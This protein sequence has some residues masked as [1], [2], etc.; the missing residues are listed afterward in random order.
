MR[1]PRLRFRH[2]Q[3]KP[4]PEAPLNSQD[5]PTETDTPPP[6]PNRAAS[7]ATQV[8]VF[9]HNLKLLWEN[10]LAKNLPPRSKIREV[11][12]IVT[13]HSMRSADRGAVIVGGSLGLGGLQDGSLDPLDEADQELRRSRRGAGALLSPEDKDP[14]EE[15]P[16]GAEQE[17]AP[18]KG[19]DRTH[20]FNYYAFE[21]RTGAARWRC[22]RR[23][24][25]CSC[26][27]RRNS[28]VKCLFGSPFRVP[29]LIAC[30]RVRARSHESA[31][32]HLDTDSLADQ[33]VPQHQYKLDAAA[34]AGRHFGEA[35]CREYRE[36]VLEVLPHRW[37][38]RGDTRFA[39][40][41]FRK[42]RHRGA[43][44]QA[45]G[46]GAPRARAAGVHGRAPNKARSR[47]MTPGR[48]VFFSS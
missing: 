24:L 8:L 41:H 27:M 19:L 3:A 12:V 18:R 28:R 10:T 22:A 45:Q 33:L 44:A 31:D 29:L 13:N 47:R 32:F 11:A 30:V 20:H 9:D 15:A 46:A 5:N 7:R 4:S 38:E 35:S 39:L 34:L 42:H 14:L 16:E 25:L 43:G 23:E 26:A 37:T 40:A 48:L 6:K 2:R 1:P 21:G 36:S 17:L